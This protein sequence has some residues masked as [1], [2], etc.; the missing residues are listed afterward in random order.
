ML[1][2]IARKLLED[3][4]FKVEHKQGMGATIILWQALTSG[5]IDMYPEYTGTISEEILKSKSPLSSD[6]MRAE[7]AKQAIGMT[8]DLGFN[9]TYTL[10]M[11]SGRAKQL[12]IR[13]ISDLKKHPE[14]VVG[15]DHEYLKRRDGWDAL[16]ARY[17]LNMQNVKGID[18]GLIYTALDAGTIDVSDVYSTDA[19]IAQ[20]HLVTLEDD[21]NFFP[22]YKAVFLYR[23]SA[24]PK[25]VAVV[26]KVEG[27]IDEAQM[28]RLNAEAEKS[29]DYRRAAM[30]YFGQTGGK[31]ESHTAV[32][33]ART[34][35]HLKLV[36]ISL[37]LAILVGVPLGIIA[38]RPGAVSQIILGVV[39]IIQTIPSLALLVLL[40]PIPFLG[41]SMWTAIVALFLYSLLPI[42]RNTATGLQDIPLPMRESAAALGLE[43]K[44]QLL[45]VYLPI[46]SRSILSG[47]KTSAVINVGTA[48]LAALIGAGGLGERIVSGLTLLDNRIIMEGAI[49]AAILALAVQLFFDGLDR[50]LIPRGL[51]LRAPANE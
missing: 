26:R 44:A 42:V 36:G 16:V 34:M 3:G 13:T 20:M 48:T 17:G 30:L 21:L 10:V 47:I 38:G 22:S 33:A 27:T 24:D 4:G 5:A 41:I 2:E 11:K 23:L 50:L 40:I 29:K 25:A 1:G 19:K 37:A 51:R 9:D 32:I 14:L 7:L 31:S 12:N 43:P 49:P 8:G 6:Q 39:G 46:A 35:E 28:V 45:K 18:H 15:I